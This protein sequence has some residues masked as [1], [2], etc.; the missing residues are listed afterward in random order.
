LAS[1]ALGCRTTETNRPV[2]PQVPPSP[3]AMHVMGYDRVAQL[4]AQAARDRGYQEALLYDA[5]QPT[6]TTWR[7]RYQLGGPGSRQLL[8][9]EYDAISHRLL[10]QELVE[11]P[12]PEQR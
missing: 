11:I 5:I 1:L 3:T 2:S 10:K 8:V 4:S 12:L 6:P 9:M 7:F